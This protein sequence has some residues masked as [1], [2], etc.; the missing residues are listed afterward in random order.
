MTPER[1]AEIEARAKTLRNGGMGWLQVAAN[2]APDDFDAL[3]AEVRH[4]RDERDTFR[5]GAVRL[6]EAMEAALALHR[7]V[8]NDLQNGFCNHCADSWPCRTARAL[9]VKA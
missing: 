5:D 7:R 1:L 2:L 4:L 3:I 9:G 8:G 6:A